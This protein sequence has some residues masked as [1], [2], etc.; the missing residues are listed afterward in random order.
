MGELFTGRVEIQDENSNLSIILDAN[1]GELSTGGGGKNGSI[2]VSGANGQEVFRLDGQR[3]IFRDANGEVVFNFN[4]QYALLDIGGQ[5]NEGDIRVRDGN[6]KNRIHFDGNSG[7]VR[8]LKDGQEVFRVDGQKIISKDANGVE[9]FSFDPK[10]ALLDIGNQGNEGDIRVRDGN[11]KNRIHFDGN[12]GAVRVLKNGQEV[13]R[14][15]G[16]KI[17]S[18]DASGVEVFSFD[19]KFALLEIGGQGNEGDIRVRDSS[20]KNRI[21]LDGHT[22]DIKLAGAD[23]AEDFDISDQEHIEPGT[24]MVIDQ[25]GRLRQNTEEYDKKVAGVISGAGECTPGIVLGKIDSTHTR[26]PVAL[27]GKVYC[28]VDARQPIDVGDLLVTSSI[29]GH[30]MKAD[31]PL[32]AF[33]AV[34]GKALRPLRS[35]LGIIPILVSL[36]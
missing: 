17:I 29:P 15:D 20:G 1:T 27:M 19:P 18:K 31:D 30:A 21:H 8:V 33:G 36:Q 6:G 24:V 25:D 35:G 5:G 12:S 22:G 13:F 4:S 14:V 32:K 2:R 11:G 26:L 7:A 10:F 23:C 3:I 16:Q 28:K 34:I 9:I